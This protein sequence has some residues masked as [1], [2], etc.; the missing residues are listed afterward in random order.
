[1]QTHFTYSTSSQLIVFRNLPTA[2]CYIRNRSK[3]TTLHHPLMPTPSIPKTGPRPSGASVGQDAGGVPKPGT[4]AVHCAAVPRAT[5]QRVT[6]VTLEGVVLGGVRRVGFQF[7][8][9]SRP[10]PI[11]LVERV[12]LRVENPLLAPKV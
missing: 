1:M 5:L 2:G 10:E 7:W 12:L 11:E 8:I 4:A 6:Q 3:V 9:E